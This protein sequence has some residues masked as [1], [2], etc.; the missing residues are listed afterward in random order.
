MI[1]PIRIETREET[2]GDKRLVTIFDLAEKE[3]AYKDFFL[4]REESEKKL[5]KNDKNEFGT[6]E[7]YSLRMEH[8]DNV[9]KTFL[10]ITKDYL[11][12]TKFDISSVTI[13]YGSESKIWV[14]GKR[15]LQ[16]EKNE[17]SKDDSVVIRPKITFNALDDTLKAEAYIDINSEDGFSYTL[18]EKWI[19]F[20]NILSN[21]N[22]RGLRGDGL[23][24]PIIQFWSRSI[25]L[26]STDFC[27][28]TSQMLPTLFKEVYVNNKKELEEIVSIRE[29][30][31]SH[32]FM[33]K[34]V[35]KELKKSY[36][37]KLDNLDN[38]VYKIINNFFGKR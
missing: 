7:D 16:K 11:N 12:A 3:K 8:E 29:Y 25:N 17:D 21:M 18:I 32:S 35:A 37:L 24:K 1:K 5:C 33:P 10:D 4:M 20:L 6:K 34:I 14:E 36:F 2:S 38:K 28:I 27:A 31:N 22:K 23:Q 9:S 15:I 26:A 30:I 19:I 13:L